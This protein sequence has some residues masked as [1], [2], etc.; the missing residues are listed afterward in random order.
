MSVIKRM[1]RDSLVVIM[2][3]MLM[4]N[5]INHNC[6]MTV[7]PDSIEIVV[8]IEPERHYLHAHATLSL[9]VISP[10]EK[11]F[12]LRLNQGFSIL[13]L[14]ID[15]H[16]SDCY[17]FYDGKIQ[18]PWDE[19]FRNKNEMSCS[20]EYE[21]AIEN[22]WESLNTCDG[23]I[24]TEGSFAMSA[25]HWY[26]G[27]PGENGKSPGT[28]TYVVPAGI[29]VASTGR[30]ISTR[31]EDQVSRQVYKVKQPLD[32]SFAAAKYYLQERKT[33][34]ILMGTYFLSGG[35]GKAR[36]YLDNCQKIIEFLTDLYGLYPFESYYLVE[37]PHA[38][39]GTFGGESEPGLVFYADGLLSGTFFNPTVFVHEMAHQY[40]GNYIFSSVGPVIT[41][42]LATLSTDLFIE[43]I[44]G[45]RAMWHYI[46]YGA[47]ELLELHSA[48]WYFQT[49][50]RQAG[51]P[52]SI[53][54]LEEDMEL[55]IERPDQFLNQHS[56]S[57]IKG[58]FIYLMLREEIG[59]DAF[60][61]GLQNCIKESAGHVINLDSL[62]RYFETSGKKDLK[63]FFDQWFFRKGAPEFKMDYRVDSIT[64]G[65]QVSGSVTQTRDIYRVN[66]EIAIIKE[67]ERDVKKIEI[68]DST[69][70]FSFILGY[71]PD[72]II[73]DPEHKIFRWCPEMVN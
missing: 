34:D 71:Q 56:L 69:T 73:F 11:G 62:R 32:F 70:V 16:K 64:D 53:F 4:A 19:E 57:N 72:K 27:I 63:W 18:V 50:S 65:Y 35:E 41:E 38:I 44:A 61:E 60:K 55:G 33:G 52:D 15:G 37:L 68:T 12:T 7:Y 48:Q 30:L 10:G 22:G 42:S 3:M 58:N 45:E 25:C 13:N 21:G 28:I 46:N 66:A 17:S 40:W 24:G 5:G 20:V 54:R 9:K 1:F 39:A 43:K 51:K 36:I 23:Y 26:P 6:E 49:F 8:T 14:S 67:G 59:R 31:I 47:P 29:T 2:P